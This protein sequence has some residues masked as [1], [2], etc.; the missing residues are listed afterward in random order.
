[1]SRKK[2]KSPEIT[3]SATAVAERDEAPT[4]RPQYID[5]PPTDEDGSVLEDDPARAKQWGNPYKAIFSTPSFELG[6]DRRFKQRV[7][8]FKEKPADDVIVVLKAAGF[9]YRAAEKAWTV[10]ADAESRKLSDGLARQLS[11]PDH[12]RSR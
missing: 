9:T 6:E 1:M 3:E 2:S 12:G 10:H 4:S 5:G 8:K 7:F 11:G